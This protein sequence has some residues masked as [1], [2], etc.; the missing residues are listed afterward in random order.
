MYK[1][2]HVWDEKHTI[3]NS[4]LKVEVKTKEITTPAKYDYRE[5]KKKFKGKKKIEVIEVHKTSPPSK[6]KGISWGYAIYD[7]GGLADSPESEL[8]CGGVT[9]KGPAYYSI[10]RHGRY[11]LWG[12]SCTPEDFTDQGKNLFINSIN[13]IAKFKDDYH[14]VEKLTDSRKRVMNT[15]EL[16]RINEAFMWML[17]RD[18]EEEVLNETEQD[19]DKLEEWYDENEPYLHKSDKKLVIDETAKK[20]KTPNNMIESIA[21]WIEMLDTK[22]D[23]AAKRL[24]AEYVSKKEMTLKEWKSWYEENK[25]YLFFSDS[26]DFKFFIDERAKKA[27]TPT[28]KFNRQS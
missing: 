20:E 28:N 17:K 2:I 7:D 14:I 9:G 12:F 6:K 24:L 4:P 22:K 10:L 16:T 25:N 21:I 8:I 5:F 11:L 23:K 1:F 15:I 26:G 19:L 13:Y 3:F 27:K 18:L